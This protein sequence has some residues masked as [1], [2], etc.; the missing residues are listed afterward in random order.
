[1]IE[2]FSGWHSFNQLFCQ[3]ISGH[4]L[5]EA[6]TKRLIPLSLN[7]FTENLLLKRILCSD[8]FDFPLA[9]N[10]TELVVVLFENL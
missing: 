1:M 8:I 10:K 3:T 6:R 5:S 4:N 2:Y 9:K 7:N